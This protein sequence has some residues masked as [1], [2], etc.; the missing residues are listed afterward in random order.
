[1]ALWVLPCLPTHMW[2]CVLIC[3]CDTC[4]LPPWERATVRLIWQASEE[5]CRQHKVTTQ[6]GKVNAGAGREGWAEGGGGCQG[7]RNTLLRRQVETECSDSRWRNESRA[8]GLS[9]VK[10]CL[11]CRHKDMSSDLH[12]PTPGSMG[13]LVSKIKAKVKHGGLTSNPSTQEAE[14]GGSLSL[15]PACSILWVSLYSYGYIARPPLNT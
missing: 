6:K 5:E 11:R 12:L 13:D 4:F 7:E 3:N 10:K 14:A 2:R 1:M 15:Q 9:S 8:W